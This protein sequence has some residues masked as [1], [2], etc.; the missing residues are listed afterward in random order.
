MAERYGDWIQ[1]ASG[2]RFWPLDPRPEDV[3]IEDI[4][5]A[6][7]LQCRFSGHTKSHYSIAEHSL[8]VMW[9]VETMY[10]QWTTPW[11]KLWA[12]LHDASE[13]YLQD[14]P[15]PIKHMPEMAAYR[16]AEMM[17]QRCVC[18]QFGLPLKM[19]RVVHQADQILCATEARDLMGAD[20][21]RDKGERPQDLKI[22]PCRNAGLV[23]EMF[24]DSFHE[25][26]DGRYAAKAK[27][28]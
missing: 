9:C 28:A 24:L 11:L 17:V 13:A 21:W 4:A 7:S 6:L 2:R 26:T 25:L 3:D 27:T 12:L 19:P 8:R 5:H 1:T 23:E 18:V 10:G 22:T 16:A 15:S 20:W 14:M